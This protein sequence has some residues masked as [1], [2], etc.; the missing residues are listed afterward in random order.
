MRP[1]NAGQK[2]FS[3]R[4]SQIAQLMKAEISIS[5]MARAS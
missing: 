1:C 4:F 5:I 2:R 3:L